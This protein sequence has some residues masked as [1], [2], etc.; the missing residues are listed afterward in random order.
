[1][2]HN[3]LISVST[4][5]L[6]QLTIAEGKTLEDLLPIF[7]G[8]GIDG[9]EL[10]EDYSRLREYG[11][12]HGR[13]DLRSR[14]ADSGLRVTSCWFNTDLLGECD[15]TSRAKLVDDIEGCFE[16]AAGLG[17]EVVVLT[18]VDTFPDYPLERGTQSFLETF[19]ALIP[20]ARS[21]GVTMGMETARSEGVFRVPHYM[22]E[23]VKQIGAPEL[24]VVPDFEAWRF[25]TPDLPLSHVETIGT[26]AAGPAEIG[27][28][29]AAL[30]YSRAIH[31]KLLR[32]DEA[33]DE[34]HFPLAEM[35]KAVRESDRQHILTIEYEGWIPDID[36]HLDCIEETRRC[37]ELLRRHL[38]D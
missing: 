28:F 25:A 38:A 18:P 10:N 32:L 20:L 19:A 11:T 29:G 27:L 23:L 7:A 14:I 24:T 5:S 26:V 34:P 35:M 36:P 4:W 2:N 22:T 3:H 15:R 21:Y 8:Y 1:M 30:P 33:G 9:I 13:R 17:S 6:Q 31:A 37:V 16:I 12:P